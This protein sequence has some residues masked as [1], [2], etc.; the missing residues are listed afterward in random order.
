MTSGV[1]L[2]GL[3]MVLAWAN[4]ANDAAKGV[5]PL[6]GSGLT[7]PHAAWL[8]AV[9][10][11][12]AGGFAAVLWG[13]ALGSLFGNGFLTGV[14]GLPMSAALAA[15]VGA[16]GFLLLATWLRWPVSTT[17]ALIGGLVGAAAATFGTDI[18]AYRVVLEKFL[19]PLLF[20]PMAALG[21]CWLLLRLNR[22]IESRLPRWRPG[23]CDAGDWRRN[24]FLCAEPRARAPGRLQRVWLALHWLSGGAVSFA[25]GLNDVPKMAALTLPALTAWPQVTA[26]RGTALAIVA[27]SLAMGLGSLMAGRRLLP[28]LA[29]RVST[30]T[31]TTGLVANLGT[32]ALVIGAAP[33]GLPVS[34]TH[35]AAGSLIGVRIADAA[36]P[37]AA[38]ALRTILYAWI[39]TLP[40]SALL[41]AA[42][43]LGFG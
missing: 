2:V 37:R 18:I 41:A 20:S 5:A 39:V 4:G 26:A 34:T 6:V 40:C 13:G 25:R 29:E 38:D 32:A 22:A 42:T 28:V 30:M 43:V 1:I 35:V 19:A 16:A 15:L 31:P 23:C 17:H 11:T 10:G 21:V 3:A 27:T 7:T 36:P 33:L 14:A 9:V 12:T 8:L 24:P